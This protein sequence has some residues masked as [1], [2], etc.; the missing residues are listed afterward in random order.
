MGTLSPIHWVLVAIVVLLVFGP[1]TLAKVGKNVGRGMRSV[2]NLKD[3]LT[4]DP[5]KALTAPPK[6]KSTPAPT[7]E[8]PAEPSAAPV[9]ATTSPERV[10]EAPEKSR[11]TGAPDASV[12]AS[13]KS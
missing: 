12:G 7:E 11:D 6:R 10:A 9:A 4:V 2:N 8:K 5:L 13:E 1:K 3:G